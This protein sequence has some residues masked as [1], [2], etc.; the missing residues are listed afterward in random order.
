MLRGELAQFICCCASRHPMGRGPART[1]S[2]LFLAFLLSM[3]HIVSQTPRQAV[4]R[5]GLSGV[6]CQTGLGTL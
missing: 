4:W 3:T 6:P 1:D 2:G 5:M